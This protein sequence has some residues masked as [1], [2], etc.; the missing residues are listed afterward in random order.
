[1]A[2]LFD[3]QD[4]RPPRSYLEGIDPISVNYPR[5]CAERIS[6]LADVR[7]VDAA[8]HEVEPW[9]RALVTSLCVIHLGKR[10]ADVRGLEA[11]QVMIAALPDHM[12]LRVK[13]EVSKHF[14]ARKA[15]R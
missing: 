15:R 7:H 12:T 11:R 1:M 14:S 10:I 8:L 4:L 13:Q 9:G 3:E 6:T 2:D 5:L